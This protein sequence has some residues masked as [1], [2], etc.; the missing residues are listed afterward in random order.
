MNSTI[1]PFLD[2]NNL[3]YQYVSIRTDFTSRKLAEDVIIQAKEEAEQA[4]R[5][6]SEFL[7]RMSHE[8]RTPMNAILGFAQLMEHDPINPLAPS[9]LENLH[10]ILKGGWHLLE[11]IN[12]VLDLARVESGKMQVEITDTNVTDLIV[13]CIDMVAPLAAK[14]QVAIHVEKNLDCQ[15]LV[16]ADNTRLKQVLINLL[17]NAVKYNIENGSVH[18]V[19]TIQGGSMLRI[20]VSDT[21]KG[22][23]L[24]NQKLL[25]M[26]FSRLDADKNGIE[27]TGI[28][29]VIS[30]RMTEL[31]GGQIGLHNA[32]GQGCTFWVELPLSQTA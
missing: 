5:A 27:G 3:P 19:C 32:P 20:N 25:F 12:E 29:L 26:P 11:L 22:L 24:E 31:M 6:K 10:Q 16:K 23:S 13:E 7:S 30:K 1:V 17:S 4:N 8:L 2:E 21:G 9:Q 14:R 18:I 15:Q 28:G